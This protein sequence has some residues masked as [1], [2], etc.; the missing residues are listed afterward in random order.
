LRLRDVDVG[1]EPQCD[2]AGSTRLSCLMPR[3]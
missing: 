2:T 1:R 3:Q